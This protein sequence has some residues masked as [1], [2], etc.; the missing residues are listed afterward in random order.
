MSLSLSLRE[1]E[2]ERERLRKT[3]RSKIKEERW[4]HTNAKEN[5]IE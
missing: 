5:A 1:R 3:H 4:Q 2:R